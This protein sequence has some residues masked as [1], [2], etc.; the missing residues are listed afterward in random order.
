M[1]VNL[2]DKQLECEQIKFAVLSSAG[3]CLGVFRIVDSRSK[4]C[5]KYLVLVK[6]GRDVLH[7]LRFHECGNAI[8]CFFEYI[9][10]YA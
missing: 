5:G 8:C 7:H 3:V 10:R 9:C 6:R 1:V 2:F 4:Y